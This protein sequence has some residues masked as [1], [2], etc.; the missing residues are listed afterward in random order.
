M[1]AEV[2]GITS[3]D[4]E[5]GAVECNTVWGIHIIAFS[6]CTMEF[7]YTEE[8]LLYPLMQI[9]MQAL[10]SSGFY[11]IKNL[12]IEPKITKDDVKKIAAG[13]Y[14]DNA[15][16]CVGNLVI[17]SLSD[18][19]PAL[20]WRVSV[21]E[22]GSMETVF[23]SATDGKI[24]E[25]FSNDLEESEADDSCFTNVLFYDAENQKS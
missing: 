3:V 10:L 18:T 13:L 19:E 9:L 12:S 1:Q 22:N 15:V 8:R 4:D 2:L 24:V 14:S 25:T 17:F 20:T 16:V 6:R 7:Q 5:L 11:P 21:K 23:V